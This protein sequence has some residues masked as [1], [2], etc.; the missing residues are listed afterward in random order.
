MKNWGTA[1]TGWISIPRIWVLSKHR[2]SQLNLNPALV[3]VV[4]IGELLGRVKDKIRGDAYR[5]NR[6]RTAE[7]NVPAARDR[8]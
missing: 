6:I 8:A 4:W 5:S 3:V 7:A 2:V 1:E